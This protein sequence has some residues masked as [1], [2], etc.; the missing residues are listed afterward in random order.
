MS[1]RYQIDKGYLRATEASKATEH[2]QIPKSNRGIRAT[3]HE[4][5][6][7]NDSG[8]QDHSTQASTKSRT[9]LQTKGNGT[10]QETALKQATMQH[11]EAIQRQDATKR[12]ETNQQQQPTSAA[13]GGNKTSRD[14]RPI[15][16][17]EKQTRQQET[18]AEAGPQQ[19]D[20]STATRDPQ[21]GG[22]KD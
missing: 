6:P 7:K 16:D 13:P 1:I 17:E 21:P 2:E 18:N 10:N 9:I 15:G 4:Q 8:N 22:T 5:I 12:N 14:Q 3:E 19:R 20:T 11:H